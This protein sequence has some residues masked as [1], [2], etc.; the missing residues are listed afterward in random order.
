MS[1]D[2]EALA[3]AV[4]SIHTNFGDVSDLPDEL[5]NTIA[6][7]YYRLHL[8]PKVNLPRTPDEFEQFVKRSSHTTT[9][10]KYLPSMVQ[11]AREVRADANSYGHV[12]GTMIDILKYGME[13]DF[14][15]HASESERKR[16]RDHR[17]V[18]EIPD[19]AETMGLLSRSTGRKPVEPFQ[20]QPTMPDITRSKPTRAFQGGKFTIFLLKDVPATAGQLTYPLVVAVIDTAAK[21]PF[22]FV[23][24]ERSDAGEF[25]CGFE[26]NGVRVNFGPPAGRSEQAFVQ[27][28]LQILRNGFQ[29]SD[30]KEMQQRAAKAGCLGVVAIFAICV[31]GFW[32]GWTS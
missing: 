27:Q 11:S 14:A 20:F 6:N 29:I 16:R 12:V 15:L 25:V 32:W 19:L 9:A 26:N 7:I 13:P 2:R 22:Y 31:M 21:R 17:K 18:D 23:T 5:V 3:G 1:I 30:V 24:L 28:A 4:Q 10:I 8:V